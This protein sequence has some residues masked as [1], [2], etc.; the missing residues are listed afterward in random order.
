MTQKDS[1]I[2]ALTLGAISLFLLVFGIQVYRGHWLH[3]LAG[4]IFGDADAELR[5]HR[6]YR[7]YGIFFMVLAAAVW[8]L[9]WVPSYV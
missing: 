2:M 4:N 9:W 7:R 6:A 8:L 3:L 5:K 1:L